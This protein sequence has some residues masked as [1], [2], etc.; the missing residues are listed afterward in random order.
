MVKPEYWTSI[1]RPAD[2]NR[3]PL[4]FRYY[5]SLLQFFHLNDDTFSPILLNFEFCILSIQKKPH[6]LSKIW[7]QNF[8]VSILNLMLFYFE[9]ANFFILSR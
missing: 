2:L 6:N 4:S 8:M 7:Y 3:L 1:L 9:K 5:P